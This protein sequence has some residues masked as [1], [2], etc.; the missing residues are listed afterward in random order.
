MF[1]FLQNGTLKKFESLDSRCEFNF[2][3]WKHFGKIIAD[4]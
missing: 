3:G 4:M 1:T 2:T